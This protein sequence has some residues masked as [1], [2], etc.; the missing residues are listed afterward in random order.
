MV[1]NNTWKLEALN[2]LAGF[3]VLTMCYALEVRFLLGLGLALA[4]RAVTTVV[5]YTTRR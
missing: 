5:F 3:A 2:G 4:A 1:S